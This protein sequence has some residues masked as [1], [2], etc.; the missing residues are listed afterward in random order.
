MAQ[1]HSGTDP[2]GLTVRILYVCTANIC[3]SPS[4]AAL[5]AD[6]QVPGVEV[7]SA[8]TMATAGAPGCSVAPALAGRYE[9][10]RSQA[11]TPDLLARADLVLTA[12]R[13]HQRVV[14]ELAPA[15]R[16][17]TF[18]IRQAGRLAQWLLDAGM[19]EAARGDGVYEDGDP[20]RF[21]APLPAGEQRTAW[22]VAELDAAR[23]MAPAPAAA[24]PPPGRWRR[25]KSE[26]ELQHPDDVGDP[27][28]L[29]MDWHGAA[30]LQIREA[31]GQLAGLL[32]AVLG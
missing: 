24:G 12:A 28:V 29:G 1:R 25:R 10:H 21:V 20:R 18:T 7:S 9:Q 2:G 19:V 26:D 5:L 17:R 23:G 11:L 6:A 3:R 15:A 32:H 16:P 27:H 22:L 13:E 14:L 31:T 30:D 8:G 4:A